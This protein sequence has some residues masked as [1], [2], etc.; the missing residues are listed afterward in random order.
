MSTA[1]T[2][3]TGRVLARVDPEPG[4]DHRVERA[5]PGGFQSG[6]TLVRDPRRGPAVL[7]WSAD[8]GWAPIVLAAARL[9]NVPEGRGIARRTEPGRGRDVE[10]VA[11][12]HDVHRPWFQGRGSGVADAGAGRRAGSGGLGA[13]GVDHPRRH[14]DAVDVVPG[15]GQQH[16]QG[17]GAATEVGDPGGRGQQRETENARGTGRLLLRRLIVIMCIIGGT[18]TWLDGPAEGL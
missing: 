8:P 4:W 16:G 12:Q 9:V 7:R 13:S 6:A 3:A 10:E 14:V 17:A 1:R 5:L 2:R 15:T 11:R 18:W